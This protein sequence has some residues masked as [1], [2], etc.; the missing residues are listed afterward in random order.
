MLRSHGGELGKAGVAWLRWHLL[1]D[2][3]W[4]GKGMLA[5]TP[6]GRRGTDWAIQM[7]FE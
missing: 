3:R 1:G 5:G 6:W 2:E 7:G 4:T